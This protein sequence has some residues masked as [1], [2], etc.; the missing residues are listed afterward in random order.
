MP[1]SI[2]SLVWF[3]LILA[4]I[5][6][7]KAADEGVGDVIL[8]KMSPFVV[9][10]RPTPHIFVVVLCFALV[11]NSCSYCPHDDAEDE[12]SN[13]EDGV[14]GS[15]FL[16]SM[17][18]TSAISDHNNDGHEQRDAGN[19]KYQDLGP[20]FGVVSPC[21]ESVSF[22]EGFRCV[23]D[24]ECCCDHGKDDKTAGEVDAS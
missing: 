10:A 6:Y 23:E 14:I 1:S 18:A 7:L 21:W 11:E 16:C 9:H 24:G 20:D 12:E 8:E 3:F 17:M 4:D 22:W 19:D 2:V 5:A 15:N 13:G